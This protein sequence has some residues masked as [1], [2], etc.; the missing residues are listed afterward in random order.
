MF[1]S[2]LKSVPLLLYEV[3][4]EIVSV[5]SN[6]LEANF[7]VILEFRKLNLNSNSDTPWK[8]VLGRKKLALRQSFIKCS[9]LEPIFLLAYII[10]ENKLERQSTK[11]LIPRKR[12]AQQYV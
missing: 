3:G 1:V 7:E 10:F 6:C 11:A 2:F 9:L 12:S 4:P 8:L 5:T